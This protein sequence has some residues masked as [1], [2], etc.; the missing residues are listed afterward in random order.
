MPKCWSGIVQCYDDKISQDDEVLWTLNRMQQSSNGSSVGAV[1]G[2]SVEQADAKVW[3]LNREAL[4]YETKPLWTSSGL[5]KWY[6]HAAATKVICDAKEWKEAQLKGLMEI[7]RGDMSLVRQSYPR[8]W[9]PCLR[10]LIYETQRD[11]SHHLCE[12][13]MEAS[14]QGPLMFKFQQPC[15]SFESF[16]VSCGQMRGFY[17]P[18][19]LT[20]ASQLSFQFELSWCLALPQVVGEFGVAGWCF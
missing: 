16:S 13:D 18:L 17:C 14:H 15:S 19:H 10:E 7:W 8:F 5:M 20:R 4:E 3:V 2:S 9:L 6:Q 11:S 12:G 1:C